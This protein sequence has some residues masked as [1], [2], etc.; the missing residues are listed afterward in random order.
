MTFIGSVHSG[1]SPNGR[2]PVDPPREEFMVVPQRHDVILREYVV[3]PQ[4]QDVIPRRPRG[5]ASCKDVIPRRPRGDASLLGRNSTVW[6][7]YLIV[8][9]RIVKSWCLM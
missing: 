9:I 3:V 6:W 7:W 1:A 5:D 2:N 8:C 4:G